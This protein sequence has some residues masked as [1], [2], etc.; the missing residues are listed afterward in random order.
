LIGYGGKE[1]NA[2]DK[3]EIPISFGEGSNFR[4]EDILFDVVDMDYPY[5]AIFGRGVLNKFGAIPHHGYLCMKMPG[6]EGVIK[7]LGDQKMAQGIEV[8]NTP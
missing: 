5:N 4:T 1:V 8:G 3:T 7:V 6:P 2:L